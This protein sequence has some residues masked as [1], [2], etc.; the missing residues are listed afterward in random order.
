MEVKDYYQI[1]GLSYPCED[2]NIIKQAY[3]NCSQIYNP[4]VYS[5]SD[6]KENL[7]EIN[8]AYLILSNKDSKL[9]YDSYFFGDRN[10]NPSG[11]LVEFIFDAN[12]RASSFIVQFLNNY[13]RNA[14][15]QRLNK[16]LKYGFLSLMMLLCFGF[17]IWYS[18]GTRTEHEEELESQNFTPPTDW[19][20]YNLCAAF[21]ISLP[22][23]FEQREL[24]IY[25]EN[26]YKVY[27]KFP[28]YMGFESDCDE[29]FQP[30]GYKKKDKNAMSKYCRI[31]ITHVLSYM[32]GGTSFDKYNQV[33][34]IDKD[35]KQLIWDY[36]KT[37]TSNYKILSTKEP[38]WENY[39]DNKVMIFE[40]T[41]SG[42]SGDVKCKMYFFS[43]SNE[44]VR[45]VTAYRESEA[46]IW[47]QDI[48][49]AIKTFTWFF[50]K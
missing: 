37:R 4:E 45:I 18:F 20:E 2:T 34:Q 47:E 41:R 39:G 42:D 48:N 36:I 49:N 22:K 10:D 28:D 40:W 31:I 32:P 7:I 43:N 12:R 15:K 25:D 11:R 21:S 17:I 33:V 50:Q 16:Y 1:L 13:Y 14:K 9:L 30:T 6:I 3:D 46:S 19:V 38:Y 27:E 8:E 29:V 5:E 24:N 35:T 44:L 26:T 23:T